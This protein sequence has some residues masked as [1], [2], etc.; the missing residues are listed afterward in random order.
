MM[1]TWQAHAVSLHSLHQGTHIGNNI[2]VDTLQ[3]D[4]HARYANNMLV[5][6]ASDVAD[7]FIHVRRKRDDTVPFRAEHLHTPSPTHAVVLKYFERKLY[8]A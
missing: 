1:R 5:K 8:C 6:L 7:G 2:N 3:R 4:Q